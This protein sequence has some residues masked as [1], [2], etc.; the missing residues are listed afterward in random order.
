MYMTEKEAEEIIS[1]KNAIIKLKSNREFK[2]V[3]TV[4]YNEKEAARLAKALANPEM[5]EDID[6]RILKEKLAAIGHFDSWLDTIVKM[7]TQIEESLKEEAKEEAK[8]V[9]EEP[10]LDEI[11]GEELGAE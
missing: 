7:A 5:Q 1:L 3:V 9:M 10:E 6:Q 4:N 2:K 8:A 11:T